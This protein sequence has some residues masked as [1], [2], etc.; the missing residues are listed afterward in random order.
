MHKNVPYHTTIYLSML[1]TTAEYMLAFTYAI[2]LFTQSE[3][4]KKLV[5]FSKLGFQ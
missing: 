3:T 1:I 4:K 5:L 2:V